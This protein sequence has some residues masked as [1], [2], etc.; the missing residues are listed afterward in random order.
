LLRSKTIKFLEGYVTEN[1]QRLTEY[2]LGE[3]T[4]HFTV[5]LEDLYDPHNVSAV[6]RTCDCFGIQDLYVSQRLNEYNVN[7]KIVKGASKW[8]S[9]NKFERS[10]KSTKDCFSVLKNKGYRLVGTT[11]DKEKA[12]IDKLDI[13]EKT[14]LVFGTEA[15]GLSD[16]AKGEVDELVHIPMYGFTKSF[17]ISVSVAL[18]LQNLVHRLKKSNIK[19]ELS[20]KEKSELKLE[21]YKKIIKK[22]DLLVKCFLEGQKTKK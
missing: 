6:I 14:A 22:S 4:R 17:N 1:K 9:L 21:W 19:W 10:E 2:V 15:S 8:V 18:V 7:P 12:S 11:P 13:S 3:R 20:E 16:F 5:V